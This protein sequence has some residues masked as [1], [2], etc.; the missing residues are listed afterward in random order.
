MC[1]GTT[2]LEGYGITECSPVV[3]VNH[4]NDPHRGT[5]GKIM[6]SLKYAIVSP[7]SHQRLAPGQEGLLLVRGSS[8]FSGYLNH[9]GLSPFVEFE[10][11]QWYRTG[12]L[13]V[14][15][16]EG[17][18][19]FRGRLQRFIKLGGEMVS[20]PAIESVLEQHFVDP[21]SEG[22]GLAVVATPTEENPDIVLFCTGDIT[23]ESANRVIR[24]A[25]LSG[26]HNIR[27]VVRAD[28]LPLLGT[29]K[30]DHQALVAQLARY[31]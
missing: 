30:I 1:P 26:L 8:V 27:Q 18:L 7:E 11:K 4:Q 6:P 12:D 28:A 31:P 22:P 13:V 17:I 21:D 29:G 3:S 10:S 9:E 5:I 19:T 16:D 25:G 24:A 20:L 2:I 23:R 14:E 15:D